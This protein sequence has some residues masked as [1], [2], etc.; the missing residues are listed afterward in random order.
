MVVKFL[1]KQFVMLIARSAK[2]LARQ[3]LTA[4]IEC[5]WWERIV[6]PTALVLLAWLIPTV[7]RRTEETPICKAPVIRCKEFASLLSLVMITSIAMH[8]GIPD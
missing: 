1:D 8:P 5:H 4:R 7:V 2:T 6:K 3:T